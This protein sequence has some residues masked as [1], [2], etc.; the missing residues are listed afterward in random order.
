MARRS[1]AKG[2]T[3]ASSVLGSLTSS[4]RAEVR[5]A[6]L[7]AHPEL[8]GTAE[9]IAGEVLSSPLANEI[10]SAVEAA[11][12]GVPLEDLGS[13]TGRVRG[14]GFVHE[15]DAAWEL[16]EEVFAPFL[17]DLERRT[18]LGLTEAASIV[19]TGIVAGLYGVREPEMGTV[20]AYA[21]EDTPSKLA[22]S[23]IDRAGKLGLA[24][25]VDAVET[26]WPDWDDLQ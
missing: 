1:S 24:I 13:R 20:L 16:I 9:R 3:H 14:R 21:G 19:A 26:Y 2:P 17:A 11:L 10:A 8:A 22:A 15:K 5:A 12:T 18:A 23:V 25:P 7:V 6:L 4:E